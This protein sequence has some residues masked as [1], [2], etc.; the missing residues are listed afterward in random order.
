MYI[1]RF[2]FYLFSNRLKES[3]GA[4]RKGGQNNRSWRCTGE[5][6]VMILFIFFVFADPTN[7]S[8]GMYQLEYAAAGAA[9]LAAARSDGTA[10]G[11]KRDGRLC[12]TTRVRR[13][14]RS[15]GTAAPAAAPAAGPTAATPPVQRQRRAENESDHQLS[16]T[17]YDG[18]GSLQ[19]VCN[20][21]AGRVLSRHE[22]LQSKPP[23]RTSPFHW[24]G[25]AVVASRSPNCFVDRI[26]LRF[27]IC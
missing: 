22:R 25:S 19:S 15:T 2:I 16:S 7:G 20:H 26:Q 14:D 1:C 10:R 11:G 3:E 12:S 5:E 9:E 6:V 27:W 13:Y 8:A 17:E 21:R 4:R 18:E 24:N 23:V